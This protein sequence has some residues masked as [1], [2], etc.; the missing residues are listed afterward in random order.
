MWDAW[1]EE[2]SAGASPTL[3]LPGN[4]AMMFGV[5]PC[6]SFW[7]RVVVSAGTTTGKEQGCEATAWLVLRQC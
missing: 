5:E 2:P 3:P 4:A 7:S 6:D 1:D